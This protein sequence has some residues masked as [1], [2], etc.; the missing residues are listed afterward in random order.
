MAQNQQ[1]RWCD[2]ARR[3]YMTVE[4]TPELATCE[5]LLLDTV[6]QRSTA[7]AGRRSLAVEAGSHRLGRLVA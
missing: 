1:L 7:L 2:L 5:W 6:R 3:G 4:L